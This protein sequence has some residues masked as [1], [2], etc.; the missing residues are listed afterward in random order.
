MAEDPNE[1]DAQ[2]FPHKEYNV[3]CCLETLC[4]G[5]TTLI[6][7]EEEAQ[8]DRT[9]WCGLCNSHKR[10]P[11]GELGTVDAETCLCFYGFA[12]GS[13]MNQDGESQCV[14]CGCDHSVVDEV[15][16]DLK[17][18]QQGRGDRAKIRLAETTVQELAILNKKVDLIMEH[19]KIQQPTVETMD[20]SVE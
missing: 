7:G 11:Y 2:R 3:T 13:L 20:R 10:G 8:I 19:L 12:A 15:V 6:L 5:S 9:C 14:G 4:C 18:R 17:A 1:P 16:A